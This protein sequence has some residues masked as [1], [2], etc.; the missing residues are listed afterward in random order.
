M[1]HESW[2]KY[3]IAYLFFAQGVEAISE[4]SEVIAMS[5]NANENELLALEIF[6]EL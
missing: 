3:S 6:S 1:P 2:Q 4:I 5:I